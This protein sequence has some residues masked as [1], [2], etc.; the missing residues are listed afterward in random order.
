[1]F[2]V[3][4]SGLEAIGPKSSAPVVVFVEP[5]G[6]TA[7]GLLP[8]IAL[9]SVQ[10]DFDYI[11]IKSDWSAL[12]ILDTTPE[13]HLSFRGSVFQLKWDLKSVALTGTTSVF[14]LKWDPKSV[15]LTGTTS[16]L[17]VYVI[18]AIFANAELNEHS[19]S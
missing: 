8:S 10:V 3:Q 19:P 9:S 11:A 1:M 2:S 15:A 4:N 12:V 5:A 16:R 18:V 13:L 7:L 17:T 6:G 14:Q